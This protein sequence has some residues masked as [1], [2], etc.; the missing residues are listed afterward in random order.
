MG[1]SVIPDRRIDSTAAPDVSERMS[2]GNAE[3]DY[4]LGGGFPADGSQFDVRDGSRMRGPAD[5]DL[6]TFDVVEEDGYVSLVQ[7]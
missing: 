6:R 1:Q 3:A 2:S 5:A 4:V 7:S